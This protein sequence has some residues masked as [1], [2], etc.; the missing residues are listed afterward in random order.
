MELFCSELFGHIQYS[1]LLGSSGRM[2]AMT[3]GEGEWDCQMM[4]Y[5]KLCCSENICISWKCCGSHEFHE[6]FI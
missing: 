6:L 2:R 4:I 3:Q 5:F 1:K